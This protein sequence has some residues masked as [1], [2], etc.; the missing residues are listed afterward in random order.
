LK[1]GLLKGKQRKFV[2]NQW[3]YQLFFYMKSYLTRGE[4]N[5]EKYI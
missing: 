4:A 3:F 5:S 1:A 2:E